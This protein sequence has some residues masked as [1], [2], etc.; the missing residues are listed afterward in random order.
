MNWV[1]WK[2]G[3]LHPSH[4]SRLVRA[5]PK[6]TEWS[7]LYLPHPWACSAFLSQRCPSSWRPRPHLTTVNWKCT[8]PVSGRRQNTKEKQ[9]SSM[10]PEIPSLSSQCNLPQAWRSGDGLGYLHVFGA[11]MMSLMLLSKEIKARIYWAL[12]MGLTLCNSLYINDL[13]EALLL[14]LFYI[15]GNWGLKKE[16]IAPLTELVDGR[17]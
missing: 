10:P 2:H 11:C 17:G 12:N 1:G 6:Q 3:S 5:S 16:K 9:T 4:P 13:P 8:L 15:W 14:S 7:S